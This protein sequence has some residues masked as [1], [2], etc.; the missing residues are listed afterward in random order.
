MASKFEILGQHLTVTDT[1]SGDV[2]FQCPKK[3]AFFNNR[4]LENESAILL[5]NNSYVGAG[6]NAFERIELAKAVDSNGDPYTEASFRSFMADNTGFDVALDSSGAALVNNGQSLE[7][8]GRTEVSQITTQLDLKQSSGQLTE[9][10]DTIT[11]GSATSTY[12]PN[13]AATVLSVSSNSDLVIGQTFQRTNYQTGKAKVVKMT[14]YSFQPQTDVVKRI[15]YYSTEFGSPYNVGIDGLFLES[16]NGVVSSNVSMRGTTTQTVQSNWNGADTSTVDWT[17]NQLL[18]I[19]FAWLG[20]AAV[21]WSLFRDGAWVLVHT[22]L[23]DNTTTNPF[24]LF[25]N[26]PFRWELQST[27]GFGT[28]AYICASA[29]IEGTFNQLGR[30]KG[31]DRGSVH[32][33]ANSTSNTY[34][35]IGIALDSSKSQ[36][37][38]ESIIDIVSGT[39]L[40]LTPDAYIWRLYIN[41][42]ISGTA[43]SWNSISN[44]GVK[45]FVGADDNIITAG[46]VITSGYISQRDSANIETSNSIKLGVDLDGNAD[47]FVIGIQPLGTNLD[48][49]CSI[50]WRELD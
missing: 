2:V 45:Y 9:F 19:E 44:S 24:I 7:A 8:F 11:V 48:I 1:L 34:A 41:P 39:T 20:V 13:N 23:F 5:Y 17:Q 38:R 18:K 26:Q 42:T 14:F 3:N 10:I 31:I 4:I 35:N 25:P 12:L 6:N 27:G 40:A 30:I 15:G 49:L 29:E 46:Q 22:D 32:Q 43:L 28:M 50:N 36:T 21:K 33:N 16:S 47:V 37:F